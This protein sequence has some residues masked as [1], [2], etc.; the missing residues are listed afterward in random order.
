MTGEEEAE[1]RERICFEVLESRL[2]F[3]WEEEGSSTRYMHCGGKQ[4]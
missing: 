2:R 3:K 4:K 1:E